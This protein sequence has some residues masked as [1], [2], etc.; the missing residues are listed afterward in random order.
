MILIRNVHFSFTEARLSCTSFAAPP[1]K[2]LKL[3][4]A[5]PLAAQGEDVAGDIHL[6]HFRDFIYMRIQ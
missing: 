4:K 5:I 3:L 6:I 2:P 1:L